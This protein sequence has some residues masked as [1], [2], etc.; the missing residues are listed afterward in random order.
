MWVLCHFEIA[1]TLLPQRDGKRTAPQSFSPWTFTG[2]Y[3][4]NESKT[5][6]EELKWYRNANDQ[7]PVGT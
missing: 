1:E 2:S 5:R 6:R 4:K 7:G 3:E